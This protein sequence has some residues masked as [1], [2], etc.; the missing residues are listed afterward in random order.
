MGI[1]KRVKDALDKIKA[2]D[3][4]GA[5]ES[6]LLGCA[7][8]S[9]KLYRRTLKH[10]N[11]RFRA[12]IRSN[13]DI[14]TDHT[15]VIS[16]G[17]GASLK[18]EYDHPNLK[19]TQGDLR[20]LEEI[21]YHIRNHQIHE[22]SFPKN[23][24]LIDATTMGAGPPLL[25]P[26]TVIY[27]LLAA[28]LVSPANSAEYLP[29]SYTLTLNGNAIRLNDYWGKR[30]EYLEWFDR[31]RAAGGGYAIKASSGTIVLKRP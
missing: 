5:L 6:A 8:T 19:P 27:G 31:A 17:T 23:I 20:T 1:G 14:I 13:I 18:I 24:Q 26:T 12:F 28:I 10:D 25:L 7:A 30:K 4:E 2:G 21:L 15:L 9:V 29:H 11:K 16:L 3:K 22:S